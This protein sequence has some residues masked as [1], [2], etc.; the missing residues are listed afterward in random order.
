[1]HP[2]VETYL[3]DRLLYY[4]MKFYKILLEKKSIF[5]ISY[6]VE[7]DRKGVPICPLDNDLFMSGVLLRKRK[8][9]FN[10]LFD[11]IYI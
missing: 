3:N 9:N 5:L 6:I 4:S 2:V 7:G 10:K 11:F 1:M 8:I